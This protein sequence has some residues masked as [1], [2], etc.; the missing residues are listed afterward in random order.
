VL[1][2]QQHALLPHD[3]MNL[4]VYPPTSGLEG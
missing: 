1:G 3:F 2:A 4:H